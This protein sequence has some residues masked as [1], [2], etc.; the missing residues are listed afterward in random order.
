MNCERVRELLL[1]TA[2][3]EAPA[4][5]RDLLARHLAAC[6]DCRRFDAETR[7]ILAAAA[8]APLEADVS[9]WTLARIAAAAQDGPLPAVRADRRAHPAVRVSWRPALA[10]AAAALVMVG[11]GIG[12]LRRAAPGPEVAALAPAAPAVVLA[13]DP[14]LDQ[15]LDTLDAVL[16]LAFEDVEEPA[17]ESAEDIVTDLA[18]LEGWEI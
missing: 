5:S 10:Y 1:L 18:R 11:L 4:D 12:Y 8:D 7:W 3:G 16:T 17:P 6:P 2:S 14:A 13:W 15:E 9:E